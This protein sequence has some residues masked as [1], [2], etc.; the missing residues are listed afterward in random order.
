MQLSEP[1]LELVRLKYL[2]DYEIE[3]FLSE[4]Y[5]FLIEYYPAIGASGQLKNIQDILN[6]FP[7]IP[8]FQKFLNDAFIEIKA[9][10][11]ILKKIKIDGFVYKKD[12]KEIESFNEVALKEYLINRL[13]QYYS[14]LNILDQKSLFLS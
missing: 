14:T 8:I 4:T 7:T 3:N 12:L 10:K 2:E 13:I 11:E 1:L 5:T 9:R 6:F